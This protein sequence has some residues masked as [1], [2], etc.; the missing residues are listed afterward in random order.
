MGVR[1][2]PAGGRDDDQYSVQTVPGYSIVD[3]A[4]AADARLGA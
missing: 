2:S 1:A 3:P 4:E